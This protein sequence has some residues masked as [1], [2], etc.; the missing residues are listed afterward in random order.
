MKIKIIFFVFLLFFW[1]IKF[2]YASS[3]EY[4]SKIEECIN[5]EQKRAIE[6]FVCIDASREKTIFQI[7]LDDKFREIDKKADLYLSNLQKWKNKYFWPDREESFLTWVDKIDAAFWPYGYFY[8]QYKRK[9]PEIISQTLACNWTLSEWIMK[10]YFSKST[11]LESFIAKKLAV[12][13][14]VAYEIM[15]LNKVQIRKDS[16]RKYDQVVRTKYNKVLDLFM[17]NIW[18]LLRIA[19][20]WPSK[21]RNPY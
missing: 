14:K 3:C 10:D 6:D 12:R 20:G 18:Y 13:R 2:S 9:I 7:V 5:T 16:K 1:F 21:T 11:M 4:T 19:L 17:E 8:K 15:Q